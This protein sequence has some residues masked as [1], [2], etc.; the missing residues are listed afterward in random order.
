MAYSGEGCICSSDPGIVQLELTTALEDT[1]AET[2]GV[3]D[4]KR[5]TSDVLRRIGLGDRSVLLVPKKQGASKK[6]VLYCLERSQIAAYIES[7]FNP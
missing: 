4:A 2:R 7:V 3:L 6:E 5:V 1:I